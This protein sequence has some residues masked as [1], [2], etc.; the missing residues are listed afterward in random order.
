[1]EADLNKREKVCALQ[2]LSD[3]A[4]LLLLPLPVIS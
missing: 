4:I 1:M 3:L 2:L